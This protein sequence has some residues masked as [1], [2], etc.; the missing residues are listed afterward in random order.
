MR[1]ANLHLTIDHLVLPDIP[2]SQRVR[3]VEIIE[4]ELGRLWMER[5]MPS[6]IAGGSLALEAAQVEITAGADALAMGRHVAH[7]LYG[8]LSGKERSI[9]DGERRKS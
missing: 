8:Q 6:T 3:L 9:S 2:P 4:Q 1:R 7:A 5:G